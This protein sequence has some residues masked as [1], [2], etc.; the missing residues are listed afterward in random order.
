MVQAE[1]IHSL[2]DCS[3]G[4]RSP[5]TVDRGGAWPWVVALVA[6]ALLTGL[7]TGWQL[8]QHAAYVLAGIVALG[9]IVALAGRHGLTV[10]SSAER[11]TAMSG[12]TIDELFVLEKRSML[13]ALWL[14][15]DDL[16]AVSLRGGARRTVRRQ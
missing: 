11:L 15:L 8:L 6:C 9:G 13:P 4:S 5:G 3:A 10:L 16:G 7:A 2:V 12:E 1:S 14:E